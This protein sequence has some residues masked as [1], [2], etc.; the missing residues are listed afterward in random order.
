[1]R[2][3]NAPRSKFEAREE[4]FH[5]LDEQHT[6]EQQFEEALKVVCRHLTAALEALVMPAA[7]RCVL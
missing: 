7:G 6:L 2:S 5:L 1:V 4:L 3:G